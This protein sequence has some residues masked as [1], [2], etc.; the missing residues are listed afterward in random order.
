MQV[1]PP[2]SEYI[3]EYG[4]GTSVCQAS[5]NVSCDPKKQTPLHGELEW[6]LHK[7]IGSPLFACLQGSIMPRQSQYV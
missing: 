1:L 3:G 7:Q 6:W 2:P 5:K 4:I